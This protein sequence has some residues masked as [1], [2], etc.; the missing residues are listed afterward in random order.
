VR[1]EL[2]A[3]EVAAI[4]GIGV[5]PEAARTDRALVR[6]TLG[7]RSL[8]E[9]GDGGA[10]RCDEADR[11]AVCRGRRLAVGRGEDDELLPIDAPARAAVAEI[12]QA[13]VAERR[14][15]RVVELARPFEIVGA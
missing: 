3:V 4:A 10:A 9:R 12:L 5:G 6:S 15:H 8:V 11:A 7:K 1:G 2:V 13:P 14:Q